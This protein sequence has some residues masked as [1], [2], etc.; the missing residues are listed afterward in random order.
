MYH[1]ARRT[2]R[3]LAIDVGIWN[4]SYARVAFLPDGGRN[5]VELWDNQSLPALAGYP[6]ANGR[7]SGN[8]ISM[9]L[10]TDICFSALCSLFPA[11][12]VLHHLDCVWI[13]SQPRFKGQAG[14]IAELSYTIYSYFRAIVDPSRL[15][16]WR[17]PDVQMV[18]AGTKFDGGS[19]FGQSASDITPGPGKK[20]SYTQRKAYGVK[21][22]TA[23]MQDQDKLEIGPHMRAMYRKAIKKD[24]FSDSLLLAGVALRETCEAA[25]WPQIETPS[26]LGLDLVEDLT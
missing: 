21:L 19:F 7:I 5:V 18:G 25:Q 4:F 9:T 11:E 3:V 14:K 15:C 26:S 22:V 13:E 20:A 1:K 6:F 12:Y 24:D 16:C 8:A 10:L 23:L 17:F 2:R